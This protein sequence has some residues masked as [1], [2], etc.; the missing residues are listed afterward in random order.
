MSDQ[1]V[2]PAA[3]VRAQTGEVREYKLNIPLH[4]KDGTVMTVMSLRRP[5]LREMRALQLKDGF[6]LGS[7]MDMVGAMCAL[8]P[9]EVDEIDGSDVIGI[10]EV[11]APFLDSGPGAKV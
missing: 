7:I 10:S 4:L 1:T 11:I 3:S 8:H 2:S 9:D 5:R 6:N